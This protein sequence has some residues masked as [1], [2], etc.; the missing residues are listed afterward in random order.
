MIVN[1]ISREAGARRLNIRDLARRAGVSYSAMHPLYHD[2]VKRI[3]LETLNRL[4]RALG[5]GVG[6][7]FEYR[8]EAAVESA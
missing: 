4:C 3:D 2:R 5:C 8:P 6:D 7:L 1:H